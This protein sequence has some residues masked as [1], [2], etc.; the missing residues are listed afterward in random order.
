[1]PYGAVLYIYAD[2]ICSPF[3][4]NIYT[5]ICHLCRMYGMTVRAPIHGPPD[6][7]PVDFY[8]HSWNMS[9]CLGTWSALCYII[10]IP[11][12]LVCKHI[13]T[14]TPC[15]RTDVPVPVY[16][17]ASCSSLSSPSMQIVW[18]SRISIVDCFCKK[19]FLWLVIFSW[20]RATLTRCFLRLPEPFCFL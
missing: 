10:P 2:C 5:C 7:L 11:G 14:S 3:I 9:D 17:Y 15:R 18:F 16:D 13:K 6:F 1:M 20:T 19:S 12:R 8:T 4:Q